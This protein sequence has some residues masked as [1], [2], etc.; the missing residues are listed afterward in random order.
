MVPVKMSLGVGIALC[1][2]TEPKAKWQR[3][4]GAAACLL[5]Q[6]CWI[7]SGGLL[8]WQQWQT[9]TEKFTR[10]VWAKGLNFLIGGKGGEE[11]E[12]RWWRVNEGQHPSEKYQGRFPIAAG[13]AEG[14]AYWYSSSSL[15]CGQYCSDRFSVWRGG[16]CT[17]LSLGKWVEFALFWQMKCKK[18][19]KMVSLFFQ[20]FFLF[21]I[22]TNNSS[23]LSH[24]YSFSVS[25][26]VQIIKF[27]CCL[28]FSDYRT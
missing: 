11:E 23:S 6:S 27:Q 14:N 20:S 16:E 3:R 21:P 24:A 17:L 28:Q 1:R 4:Q 10:S 19:E 12:G 8:P 18:W 22:L 2:P 9:G 15:N 5:W 26:L 25:E 7:I 13:M